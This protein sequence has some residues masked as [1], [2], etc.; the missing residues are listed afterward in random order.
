MV[1]VYISLSAASPHPP[2]VKASALVANN[3]CHYYMYYIIR[4]PSSSVFRAVSALALSCL[5]VVP[6]APL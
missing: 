5:S 1:G 2:L 4:L 6:F 3:Y